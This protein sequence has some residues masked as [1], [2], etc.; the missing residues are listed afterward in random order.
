MMGSIYFAALV[1]ALG[2]CSTQGHGL[3][4][5]YRARGPLSYNTKNYR[6]GP[7]YKVVYGY[8]S[9]H[10][11]PSTYE[12]Q[13]YVAHTYKPKAEEKQEITYKQPTK[14]YKPIVYKAHAGKH[15]VIL[16]RAG[17]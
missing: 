10:K 15:N 16:L 11:A 4:G 14:A 17:M 5:H 8:S 2:L 3:K 13:S 7:F 12:H 6:H 9:S 1:L